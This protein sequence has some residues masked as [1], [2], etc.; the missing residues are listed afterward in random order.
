MSSME[1]HAGVRNRSGACL[2]EQG[3]C[4]PVW[5]VRR[6]VVRLDRKH[7]S[8]RQLVQLAVAKPPAPH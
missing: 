4:G 2:L 6:G 8:A 1:L 7:G 3:E 5:R